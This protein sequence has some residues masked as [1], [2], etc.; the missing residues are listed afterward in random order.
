M[1]QAFYQRSFLAKTFFRSIPSS[2][3]GSVFATPSA[4]LSGAN[5]QR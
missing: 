3:T 2:V 1:A 4:V 5:D